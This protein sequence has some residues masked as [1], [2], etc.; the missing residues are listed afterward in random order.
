MSKSPGDSLIRTVEW[1]DGVVT[2]LDQRLL[3][4]REVYIRCE[5]CSDVADAIRDMVIRGAPAIGIA[6]A[7]GIVL[8]AAQAIRNH[9]DGW[10]EAIHSDL[11]QLAAA[12]PTAVNLHWAINRMASHFDRVRNDTV[13]TL[14]S[15]ARRIHEA[16]VAANHVMGETG[17]GIIRSAKG[18]LTHCNA[19]ALATG[20]YG[21][22]LGVIRS[23]CRMFGLTDIYACETRPW[24]Q[25]ARL[26][27]WELGK[28]N[29]PA[30]LIADSSA[31]QLMHTGKIDWVI[32]GADRIAANG[33]TAN[34]I[35]T[36]SLALAARHHGL[37]FMVVAPTSTIDP[38]MPSGGDIPIEERPAAEFYDCMTRLT[39]P[40]GTCIYNPV[41]DVTPADLIDVMV[42][43]KGAVQR[44][45]PEKIKTLLS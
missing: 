44:P 33:D 36:Y 7:Y 39:A 12:R 13:S 4:G 19:G 10:R 18:V 35:G 41:F 31:A 2:M 30:T 27:V 17:A 26:T 42:T 37:N 6:A 25:G 38:D 32:V 15:E 16:D 23:A 43:E 34:K 9:G 11:E 1:T 45:D 40:E 21:T 24:L 14:L 20:G 3:P 22:A 29:I 5:T 28:D 8:A